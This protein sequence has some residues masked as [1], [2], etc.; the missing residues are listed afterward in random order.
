M[1]IEDHPQPAVLRSASRL[2]T[3]HGYLGG[4]QMFSATHPVFR[5]PHY[6]DK[7]RVVRHQRGACYKS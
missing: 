3:G 4:G 6:R 2:G 7:S 5:S 1:K